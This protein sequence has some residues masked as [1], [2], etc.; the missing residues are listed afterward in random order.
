MD[1]LGHF[2]VT[3]FF[4][5]DHFGPRMAL[6]WP[7]FDPK[8]TPLTWSG[9]SLTNFRPFLTILWHFQFLAIGRAAI[10]YSRYLFGVRVMWQLLERG[11][12]HFL[13]GVC[14]IFCYSKFVKKTVRGGGYKFEFITQTTCFKRIYNENILWR[15]PIFFNLTFE[16]RGHNGSKKGSET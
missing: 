13:P 9:P 15:C 16:G 10:F 14:A 6:S 8:S 11:L 2:L 1:F 4:I 12:C 7:H 5:L 3:I